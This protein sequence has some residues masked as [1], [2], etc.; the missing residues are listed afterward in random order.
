MVEQKDK[1]NLL[2]DIL[3]IDDREVAD[4]I[5]QRLDTITQTLES[6]EKLA[7]KVDPIFEE[8]MEQFVEEIPT[9]LGPVITKTLKEQIANSKDQ[10]VEALY[11]IL[12]KMVK[13]YIQNE[14]ALLSENI[15][16]KV[17]NTFTLKGLQRKLKALFTGVK[18]SDIILSE[19][20][21]PE[22]MEV[23][24]IKKG[25]GM[26]LG[27]Y[28]NQQTLDKDLISGMLTAIKSFVE[29]AFQGESQ[30]LE[31]IDYELYK[32][33]IQN[34]HS[35][36]MAVVVSGNLTP[37]F[38][39]E[40]EDLILENSDTLSELLTNAQRENVDIFLASMFEDYLDNT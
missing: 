16:N 12:G 25:S 35:Y 1:L 24:V 38:E 21:A 7:K 11:P 30:N 32:I 5:S 15:N 39:N 26:L 13:R 3:L 37:Q 6:K 27:N 33:Q 8:N 9:R 22:L 19:L 40:I 4:A 29:D 20:D 34:F 2:R 10:V 14:L 36:Y 28:S 18:E 31:G 17:N 23:F